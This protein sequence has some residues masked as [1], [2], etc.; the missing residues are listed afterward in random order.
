MDEENE[1]ENEK[2]DMEQWE[3]SQYISSDMK[4]DTVYLNQDIGVTIGDEGIN[5]I[6]PDGGDWSGEHMEMKH[7][8][9]ALM[10]VAR[11]ISQAEFNL[12]APRKMVEDM[13][14]KMFVDV[15][16]ACYMARGGVS[17]L[18]IDHR[19]V[20]NEDG[21]INQVGGHQE[22]RAPIPLDDSYDFLNATLGM[23]GRIRASV[24]WVGGLTD[25]S[26]VDDL[27][28]LDPNSE[29]TVWQA[30]DDR[31]FSLF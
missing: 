25:D 9:V 10:W 22:G 8:D 29:V 2:T 18:R 7:F 6:F 11:V 19:I 14:G 23:P 16:A 24:A 12:L 27:F 3:L 5:P 31:K 26:M 15:R 17:S 30:I 4:Y 28:K 21:K 20:V 1:N 13:S